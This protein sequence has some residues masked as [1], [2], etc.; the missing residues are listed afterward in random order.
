M[1]IFVR[2]LIDN[3]NE[4]QSYRNRVRSSRFQKSNKNKSFCKILRISRVKTGPKT[5]HPLI[6]DKMLILDFW[7]VC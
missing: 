2:F 4:F 3:E 1:E 7:L 5:I 6:F